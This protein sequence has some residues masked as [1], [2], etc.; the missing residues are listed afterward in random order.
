MAYQIFISYRREGGELLGKILY[1]RLKE[2]GYTVFYDVEQMKS[3]AFNEQLYTHIDGCTDF[4]LLLSPHALDRCISD[5]Q[6]WVLREVTRAIEKKKNIIP[7]VMRD[8]GD[9]PGNLPPAIASLPLY[10]RLDA[11]LQV[12]FDAAFDR[13]CTRLLHSVPV[14]TA[15]SRGSQ[16][17]N[18]PVTAEPV[19]TDTVIAM[20]QFMKQKNIPFEFFMQLYALTRENGRGVYDKIEYEPS[21]MKFMLAHAEMEWSRIE[22][23][24]STKEDQKRLN[25]ESMKRLLEW[26]LNVPDE[27]L[28]EISR[29]CWEVR[30]LRSICRP[31]GMTFRNPIRQHFTYESSVWDIMDIFELGDRKW[32]IATSARNELLPETGIFSLEGGS[33]VR[34][35]ESSQEYLVMLMTY[36]VSFRLMD[37]MPEYVKERLG[38][39]NLRLLERNFA[40]QMPGTGSSWM[41]N[42]NIF[43][44][45][46]IYG[47]YNK[48]GWF[49]KTKCLVSINM[50][51]CYTTDL[52]TKQDS[53]LT[54]FGKE[55]AVDIVRVREDQYGNSDYLVLTCPSKARGMQYYQDSPRV[56][57]FYVNIN[58]SSPRNQLDF[59]EI[60]PGKGALVEPGVLERFSLRMAFLRKMGIVG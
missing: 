21:D 5:P 44:N 57:R 22:N 15:G 40:S 53:R 27:K 46:Y 31:D 48:K 41:L 28:R 42:N 25:I 32:I 39:D 12:Y 6:D 37:L 9:F 26:L 58:T 17:D 43:N 3:G 24:L 30:S 4:L 59:K 8:F 49:W 36:C 45:N 55:Q 7:V 33:F 35:A 2:A 29:F 10:E 1:D 56:Y 18:Y 51:Y 52:E 60:L 14:A 54:Q 20:L 13:L 11:S 38:E 34:M 16:E 19:M 50:K 23:E 47:D